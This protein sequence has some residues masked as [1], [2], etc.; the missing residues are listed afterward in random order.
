[1][2][3]IFRS[4]SHE[5]STSLNCIQLFANSSLN[6]LIEFPQIVDTYINPIIKSCKLKLNKNV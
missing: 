3:Q 6:D 5:F 4:F 1:M 2:N